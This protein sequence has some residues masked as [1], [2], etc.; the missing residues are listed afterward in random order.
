MTIVMRQTPPNASFLP[1]EI[2][3]QRRTSR[4]MFACSPAA[5]MIWVTCLRLPLRRYGS[6]RALARLLGVAA[7]NLDLVR[8]DGRTAIVHLECDILDEEGPDFV[9]E[10]I[11]IKTSL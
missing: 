10:S 2:V 1:H 7:N 8:R 6:S 11:G 4:S 5:H 9:A 3:A